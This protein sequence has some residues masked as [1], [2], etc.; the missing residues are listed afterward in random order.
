V[1]RRSIRESPVTLRQS[2]PAFGRL[3][4]LQKRIGTW[5]QRIPQVHF[6]YDDCPKIRDTVRDRRH[7]G[8]SAMVGQSREGCVQEQDYLNHRFQVVITNSPPTGEIGA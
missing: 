2:T 8:A 3:A 5:S 1:P 6:S 7:L 4:Q